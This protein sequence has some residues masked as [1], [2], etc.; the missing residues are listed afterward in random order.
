MAGRCECRGDHVP[1]RTRP[2]EGDS[3]FCYSH[4]SAAHYRWVQRTDPRMFAEVKERV[5]EGR[6]EVVGGWPVE[7]DCNVPS[8]ES[9]VRHALY[10]KAYLR[11]ELGV[12]VD[13]GFNPDSFGHAAGLPTLLKQAGYRY[14]VF[15]RPTKEHS[16]RE[17]PV[18]FWWEGPDGSRL[19]ALHPLTGYSAPATVARR[20]HKVNL[21]PGFTD[22]PFF[23]GI[24]NHGGG[25]TREQIKSLLEMRPELPELRWSTLRQFFQAVE[26]SPAAANLP[27]VRGELQYVARGCYSAHGE[28]KR[29]NRRAERALVQ[30]ETI[31]AAANLSAGRAY[32][33]AQ[34]DA[35]WWKV[36]FNQFHDSLGGTGI[37]PIYD[38]MRDSYGWATETANQEKVES[39]VTL[40]RRVDTRDVAESAIFLFNPLPWKRKAVLEMTTDQGPN[41]K[42]DRP[43]HL[44]SKDGSRAPVQW[45]T[46]PGFASIYAA[47]E[48]PP[49]GYKVFELMHGEPPAPQ[50]YTDNCTVSDAALGLSSL[51]AE[52]GTELLAGPIG[53]VVID[54][55]TDAWGHGAKE[56]YQSRWRNK[57]GRPTFTSSAVVEDG[58][59]RRV[60][61][62]VAKWRD[63]EIVLEIV[64]Y[65]GMDMVEF[66]F[67]IDWHERWQMLKL[68]VPDGIRRARRVREGAGRRGSTADQRRRRARAG[69][70]DYTRQGWSARD[71]TIALLNDSTY[72]Y[73]CLGGLLRTVLIRSNPFLP[74]R[75]GSLLPTPPQ[76]GNAFMD[77]GRQE[78]R[79][80]LIARSD[81]RPT[82]SS[83]RTAW[84][85][86][87]RLRRSTCPTP[88]TPAISRGRNHFWTSRPLLSRYWP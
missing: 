31:A 36:L 43:S 38:D 15:F 12:E 40:A 58:P 4:S 80:C 35:A 49:C 46:R 39:L 11:K 2:D 75:T 84:R 24:G 26:K 18:L 52:D 57:I 22:A 23:L 44:R 16:P 25:V 71:Y 1:Q 13:V 20:A 56:F 6:W 62:Q 9:F 74:T 82:T 77:Q 54:D 28:A 48:L 30:G 5:R 81:R 3:G 42:A 41:A 8:T 70:G 32:P 79:F 14:Y 69:L 78:R 67:A 65:A 45:S 17:L 63:S 55:P 19:L 7:P 51:R 86:T 76:P 21:A 29:W 27:V 47:V 10:G 59:V 73:D 33:G 61:R 85:K 37:R 83:F 68:E 53:L 64:R 87:G 60:V 72:S 66:R 34:F 50:R 88:R